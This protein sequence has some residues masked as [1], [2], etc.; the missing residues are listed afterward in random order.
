MHRMHQFMAAEN[1]ATS[2]HNDDT[3]WQAS[4]NQENQTNLIDV[5]MSF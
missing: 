1:V 4:G 5:L 3:T 2:S